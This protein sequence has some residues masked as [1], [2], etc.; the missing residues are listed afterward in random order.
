MGNLYAKEALINMAGAAI[1]Y[2]DRSLWKSYPFELMRE[3]EVGP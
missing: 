2:S 1:V 3:A